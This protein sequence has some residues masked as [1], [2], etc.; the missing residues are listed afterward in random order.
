GKDGETVIQAQQ[1]LIATGS[2]PATL[3]GIELDGDRVATSTEALSWEEIPKSLIVIGAGAIGLE[4]GTVWRRLGS[5]VTVL[6]YFDRILPGMDA[7]LAADALKLFKKQ[8][9][10]FQLGC[11][12]TGVAVTADGCEVQIEGSE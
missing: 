6:E 2:V 1:I 12:V 10:K 4:L 7:E 9:L 5:Q 3:P 8:G 11:R